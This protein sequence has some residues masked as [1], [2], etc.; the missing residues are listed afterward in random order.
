MVR[1]RAVNIRSFVVVAVLVFVF[2]IVLSNYL[3]YFWTT[4]PMYRTV[5]QPL[6]EAFPMKVSVWLNGILVFPLP[7]YVG[8]ACLGFSLIL[9]RC[10][11]PWSVTASAGTLVGIAIWSHMDR[12]VAERFHYVYVVMLLGPPVIQSLIIGFLF[13]ISRA[14][15][16]A[17]LGHCVHCGYNLHANVSGICPECGAPM[18]NRRLDRAP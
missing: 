16:V 11:A 7:F 18:S 14:R 9:F 2:G 15:R 4:T 5:A 12:L 13:W 8:A 3:L 6:R 10:M 1:L 17:R